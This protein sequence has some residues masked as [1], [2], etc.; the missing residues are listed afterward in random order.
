MTHKI[1]HIPVAIIQLNWSPKH[2][3]ISLI[4]PH[5]EIQLRNTK[6]NDKEHRF[7]NLFHLFPPSNRMNGRN[8]S[9]LTDIRFHYSHR[10][11]PHL[12]SRTDDICMCHN[13]FFHSFFGSSVNSFQFSMAHSANPYFPLISSCI[14]NKSAAVGGKCGKWQLMLPIAPPDIYKTQWFT[15]LYSSPLILLTILSANSLDQHSS[16]ASRIADRTLTT[17]AL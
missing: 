10:R 5:V 6:K 17:N 9:N 7:N 4:I 2:T 16:S 14:F 8:P 15:L 13:I 3:V 12:H 1:N 11:N